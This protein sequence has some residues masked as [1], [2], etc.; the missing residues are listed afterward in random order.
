MRSINLIPLIALLLSPLAFPQDSSLIP[1]GSKV[2]IQPMGGYETFIA[3][4]FANKKV[5]VVVVTDR[6]AADFEVTG[7]SESQKAG[8]A[9]MLLTRQSSSSEEASITVV[10]IK[11]GTVVFA[12]AV[13]KMNSVH[14]RQSSAEAC[15]KHLKEK[16]AKP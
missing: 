2:F 8:W 15:A 5:P 16:I 13:N 9:K 4:A 12:Y 1:R 11:A 10:N 3:A 14:G 7:S 6:N